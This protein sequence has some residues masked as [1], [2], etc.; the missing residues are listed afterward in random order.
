MG[1][2]CLPSFPT[3]KRLNQILN[4]L[5]RNS[6]HVAFSCNYIFVLGIFGFETYLI[7][8]RFRIKSF[9]SVFIFICQRNDNLSDLSI[10][11]TAD[12]HQIPVVNS[13]SY[14][15]IAISPQKE[16]VTFPKQF[17]R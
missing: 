10:V 5:H 16:K 8:L 9:Q 15:R 4:N 13:C 6:L 3:S 12:Q 17:F 11:T 7:S 14:H 2:Q 1:T